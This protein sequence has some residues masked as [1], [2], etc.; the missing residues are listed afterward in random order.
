MPLGAGPRAEGCGI[1]Y[2]SIVITSE[3]TLMS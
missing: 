1:V 3:Q 2:E